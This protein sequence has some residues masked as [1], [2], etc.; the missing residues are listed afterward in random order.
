[1]TPV[2]PYYDGLGSGALGEDFSVLKMKRH[3][4]EEREVGDAEDGDV[5]KEPLPPWL[6]DT[7]TTLREGHPLRLLL[8]KSARNLQ[9]AMLPAQHSSSSPRDEEQEAIF[10][11]YSSPHSA[12]SSPMVPQREPLASP[13]TMRSVNST[14]QHGSI[15]QTPIS[16]TVHDTPFSKPGPASST[17]GSR[18]LTTPASAIPLFPTLPSQPRPTSALSASSASSILHPLSQR[19]PEGPFLSSAS[20][21][22]T[23]TYSS[24]D[25]D[26][27]CLSP[28][29]PP[30]DSCSDIFNTPGPVYYTSRPLDESQ[31]TSSDPPRPDDLLPDLDTSTLQ[32]QWTPFDRKHPPDTGAFPGP[33]QPY[34]YL[35]T[36]AP[37]R[38]GSLPPS[39]NHEEAFYG[40]KMHTGVDDPAAE[41]LEDTLYIPDPSGQRF[42]PEPEELPMAS[43]ND[44]YRD[45]AGIPPSDLLRMHTGEKFFPQME[46]TPR[47]Q[48]QV[49]DERPDTACP[50]RFRVSPP[51]RPKDQP[52]G[53]KPMFTPTRTRVRSIPKENTPPPDP[54]Q[55]REHEEAQA[56]IATAASPPVFA[57]APGVYLSPLRN[58]SGSGPGENIG[59]LKSRLLDAIDQVAAGTCDQRESGGGQ[60]GQGKQWNG[61]TMSAPRKGNHSRKEA[62]DASPARGVSRGSTES[63][64]SWGD[65]E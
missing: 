63:I 8:P 42:S 52:E 39:S 24:A 16:N 15:T 44:D 55:G 4:S 6:T 59:N 37:L 29:A 58:T 49:P 14:L 34:K 60:N 65:E 23:R 51:S 3:V 20:A 5:C 12:P 25:F 35:H 41:P 31:P 64:E 2:D 36:S 53:R 22:L 56:R 7:F 18:L 13:I 1:M 46:S 33:R 38:D 32:F 11:H 26:D 19:E 9:R 27:A 10:T 47:A 50:F 28:D 61:E 17:T 21:M 43:S 57:P 62:N 30:P 54:D 48:A 40:Y 45:A